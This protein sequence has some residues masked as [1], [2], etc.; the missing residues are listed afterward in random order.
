MSSAGSAGLALSLG[1]LPLP[2]LVL[3]C[4]LFWNLPA[5]SGKQIHSF[6]LHFLDCDAYTLLNSLGLPVGT[7]TPVTK[8]RC[9]LSRSREER[10]AVSN[11]GRSCKSLFLG[12]AQQQVSV[13]PLA[14][15][16]KWI[17]LHPSR[18]PSSPSVVLHKRCRYAVGLFSPRKIW[19]IAL[20]RA[21]CLR[22]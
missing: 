16:S 19:A 2:A 8:E 3:S 6:S 1:F 13:V 18:P 11:S 20:N 14:S 4:L 21:R 17:I 10:L 5:L 22:L 15:D 7:Q 12:T 9:R